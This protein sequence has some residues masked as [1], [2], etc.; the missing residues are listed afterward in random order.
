[1]VNLSSIGSV[2]ITLTKPHSRLIWEAT[3]SSGAKRRIS[4]QWIFPI[5]ALLA[6]TSLYFLSQHP[7]GWQTEMPCSY[8]DKQSTTS[9]LNKLENPLRYFVLALGTNP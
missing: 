9:D 2:P 5:W 7:A 6:K 4:A 1:M 8:Y 3:D